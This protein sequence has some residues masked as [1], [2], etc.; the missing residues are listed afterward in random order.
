VWLGVLAGSLAA[1]ARAGIAG[2]HAAASAAVV[3][4]F[5][6][7]AF[8]THGLFYPEGQTV[9]ARLGPAAVTAEGLLHAATVVA[10]TAALA[11]AGLAFTLWVDVPVLRAAL[12]R[13]GVPAQFGHVVAAALGL[14]PAAAERLRR[15]REAQEA[16][17]LLVR[18]GPAGRLAAARFQALPLVL[19]LVDEA[20]ERALALES[21]GQGL[22][23]RR[24]AYAE[25]P[26]SAPQRALR[27][28]LAAACLLGTAAVV[29]PALGGAP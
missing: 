4:P 25:E 15:I 19:A 21:R 20:G 5:A 17:G 6:L 28:T 10:R 22:P 18:P 23:G 16:R 13:R 29:V 8:A 9:L 11:A 26:D 3:A 1:A 27:W 7:W 12:A 14:V 2:R 24:T